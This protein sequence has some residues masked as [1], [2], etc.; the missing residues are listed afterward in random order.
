[1]VGTEGAPTTRTLGVALALARIG[2][3][4][5]TVVHTGD[6]GPERDRFLRAATR[7]AISEGI[8]EE[9][10]STVSRT[11]VPA[12]VIAAIAE[13]T[14]AQTIVVGRGGERPGHTAHRLS[15]RSPCDLLVV[16]DIGGDRVEPYRRIAV[17][18][19]GSATADR[20]ARRG[21]DVA[22]ATG[23]AVDLVFVGNLATGAL[24]S[25]DTVAVYGDEIETDVHLLQGDPAKR[26]LE[27]A[28]TAGAGLIVIGNKGLTGLKGMVLGSV[29]RGV[30]NGASV[31]VLVVRTVRQIESQLQAGE[32]GIVER[33]GEKL[34]AFRDERGDL[35][36]M[37]A[38]CT[39][40]GCIVGWNPA[41]STFDCPCHGSRFSATGEV[42]NGPAAR[43][44]PPA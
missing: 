12:D 38:R 33:H 28:N 13:E 36:T 2:S 31:D 17:A 18:T 14:D 42:V 30:L 21:Y 7:T 39:H 1:V 5:L 23:A 4:P 6:S 24:I 35:H 22:R 15:H 9:R 3:A 32:G 11:G 10:I 26:I 16:A 27:T 20:A 40:L 44:L 8:P 37:S 25:N 34:A 41:E 29:P 19:D 43:P